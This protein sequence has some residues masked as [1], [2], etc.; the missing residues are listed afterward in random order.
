MKMNKRIVFCVLVML[1]MV[2]GIDAEAIAPGDPCRVGRT[3][4]HSIPP[5]GFYTCVLSEY[6]YFLGPD[7]PHGTC[8]CRWGPLEAGWIG[9]GEDVD[10]VCQFINR[11]GGAEAGLSGMIRA[12][13]LVI[14]V[15]VVMAGL[16]SIVVGGYF[17]MTAAGNADRVRLA[18][19]WIGS[20][21]LGIALALLAFTIL[22]IISP[23]LN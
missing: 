14:T 6:T 11:V 4:C 19:V 3:I 20:A 16:I 21:L 23:N 22:S 18:K 8:Q 9:L 15:L 12:L 17:Y 7:E 1:L 5:A 13:V 2:V 10:D